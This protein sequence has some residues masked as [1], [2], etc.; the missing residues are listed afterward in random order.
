MEVVEVDEEFGK[1]GAVFSLDVGDQ[2]LG[3]DAFFLGAQH[4]GRA[5]GVVCADISALIAAKF[6]EA[7]PHIGLDVLK[8]MAKVN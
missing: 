7:H 3:C 5:V 6:L 1:V 2:L 8:H 4:D